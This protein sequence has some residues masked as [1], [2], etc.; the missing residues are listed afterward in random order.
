MD[1]TADK[2][3]DKNMDKTADKNIDEPVMRL[4]SDINVVESVSLI[5]NGE[6]WDYYKVIQHN[7][8]KHNNLNK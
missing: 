2:N 4:T 7:N 6:V 1:K 3:M 5:V 8:P